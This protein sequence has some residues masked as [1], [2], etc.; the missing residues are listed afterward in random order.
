MDS[1]T[2]VLVLADGAVP[3]VTV[4]TDYALSTLSAIFPQTLRHNIAFMFTNVLSP[5]HWNFSVDTV[6]PVLK[7]APQF[8]LNNPIALQKEYLKL[9]VDPNMKTRR[10]D[11]RNAVKVGEQHALRMLVKLFHWLDGLEP[12]STR[13]ITSLY[14]MSQTIDA[15]TTNILAQTGQAATKKVE[16]DKQLQEC[17]KYSAV[18]FSRRL[19]LVLD[20]YACCTKV[21]EDS[22]DFEKTVDTAVWE[23]QYSSALNY[24]CAAPHCYS[25]CHSSLLFTP[26]RRLFRFC[27]R[28][29]N[30]SHRSHSHTHHQWVKVINPQ[31]LVD[32]GR[33]RR[34]K[35]AK[36]EKEKTEALIASSK[37][38]LGELGITTEEAMDHLVQLAEDYTGHSLAGSLSAPMEAAIWLLG[39]RCTDMAKKGASEKQ[40]KQAQDSLGLMKRK[41]VLLRDAERKALKDR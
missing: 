10:I 14:E 15:E 25:T 19:H 11:L 3:G 29:C 4:G 21:I 5:L 18:S 1:I 20:S 23:L 17:R 9:K 39:E 40:L 22:S 12:Q 34:W 8:F 31:R 13:E 36:D 28:K 35:A 2:A 26:I 32:E 6:P 7:D 33:Q 38:V 16:I 27:C 37:K 24:L 41:L 30:H